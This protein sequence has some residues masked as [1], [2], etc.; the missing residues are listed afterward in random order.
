VGEVK[1]TGWK[2]ALARNPPLGPAALTQG[3][4]SFLLIHFELIHRSSVPKT[5]TLKP[6]LHLKGG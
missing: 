4:N 2:P 1:K 3:H 6:M 5:E